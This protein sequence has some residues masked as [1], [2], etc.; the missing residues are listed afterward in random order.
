MASLQERMAKITTVGKAPALLVPPAPVCITREGTI[1]SRPTV[2][3]PP[4]PVLCPILLHKQDNA[5][6][7]EIRTIP[8]PLVHVYA[9]LG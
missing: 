5:P 9:T 3:A 7:P 4:L 2:S 8:E 1:I 6:P